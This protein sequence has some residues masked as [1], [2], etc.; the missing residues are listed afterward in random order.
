LHEE[1]EKALNFGFFRWPQRW[2]IEVTLDG[3]AEST[4]GR[5]KLRQVSRQN[6]GNWIIGGFAMTVVEGEL[7]RNGETIPVLG[8]AELIK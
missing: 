5:L 3:V 7:L 2:A 4:P 8:F 1:Y 6:Q